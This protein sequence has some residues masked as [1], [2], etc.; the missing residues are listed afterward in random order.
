MFGSRPLPL[1]VGAIRVAGSCRCSGS[2]PCT[3]WNPNKKRMLTD[4]N[5]RTLRA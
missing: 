5:A 1:A 4:E 3:S 2:V